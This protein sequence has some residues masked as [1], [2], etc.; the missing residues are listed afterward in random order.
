MIVFFKIFMS[1]PHLTTFPEENLFL[2]RDEP[3]LI[4]PVYT[5]LQFFFYLGW[6]KV[7]HTLTLTHT[8]PHTHPH[9]H[10]NRHTHGVHLATVLLLSGLAP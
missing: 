8:H 7:A 1:G 6:L 3:D 9:T 4:I 10:T 2:F 5:F